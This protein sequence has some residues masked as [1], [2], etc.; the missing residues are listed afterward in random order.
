MGQQ[1]VGCGQIHINNENLCCE[2]TS[3]SSAQKKSGPFLIPTSTMQLE[4][5]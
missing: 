4:L 1:A 5:A 3:G 2:N